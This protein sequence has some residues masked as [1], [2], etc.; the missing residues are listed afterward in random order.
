[1]KAHTLGDQE[2][3]RVVKMLEQ[4]GRQPHKTQEVKS[5]M[6]ATLFYWLNFRSSPINIECCERIF[7]A[8]SQNYIPVMVEV[9]TDD[10][11]SIINELASDVEDFDR[12][13]LA[14][15][16][17]NRTQSISVYCVSKVLGTAI[18]IASNQSAPAGG[19]QCN[20]GSS[21]DSLSDFIKNTMLYDLFKQSVG[22]R[23]L[24]ALASLLMECPT[25]I[26]WETCSVLVNVVVSKLS[27]CMFA[28]DADPNTFIK[29]CI[30]VSKLIKYIWSKAVSPKMMILE[31]LKT[32]FGIVSS[33]GTLDTVSVALSTVLQSVPEVCRTDVQRNDFN[34]KKA[35]VLKNIRIV[36]S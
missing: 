32:L 6:R 10:F 4:S 28:S 19:L 7:H 2:K 30:R 9:L 8:W 29:Q 3:N 15:N 16:S 5:V 13:D 34:Y 1:M 33:T 35:W 14:M 26:P 11:P 21:L 23:P 25:I 24:D 31:S 22:I 27:T 17:N 18:K 12:A 36:R 20:N